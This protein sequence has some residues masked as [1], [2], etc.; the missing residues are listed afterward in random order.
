MDEAAISIGVGQPI[1]EWDLKRRLPTDR[2]A[3]PDLWDGGTI[4]RINSTYKHDLYVLKENEKI[5]P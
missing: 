4:F 2:P 3:G 1:P 5:V